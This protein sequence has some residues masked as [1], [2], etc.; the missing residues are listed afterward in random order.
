MKINLIKNNLNLIKLL[1]EL[2]SNDLY[3][4]YYNAFGDFK[5]EKNIEG[6]AN[7]EKTNV[8]EKIQQFK[9]N[10]ESGKI[11]KEQVSAQMIEFRKMIKEGKITDEQ[12]KALEDVVQNTVRQMDG[13]NLMNKVTLILDLKLIK[14]M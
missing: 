6:F 2:K 9:K 14:V 5:K 11:T 10:L 12:K 1:I 7:D 4:I 3:M 13:I 8:M